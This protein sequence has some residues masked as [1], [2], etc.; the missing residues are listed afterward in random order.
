[1]AFEFGYLGSS[2]IERCQ[3]GPFSCAGEVIMES[4]ETRGNTERC[5]ILPS[6]SSSQWSHVVLVGVGGRRAKVLAVSR[7]HPS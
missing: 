6:L 4:R 3:T 7:A 2:L 1:M 5:D